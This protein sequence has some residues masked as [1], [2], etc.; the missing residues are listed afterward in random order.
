[1]KRKKMLNKSIAVLLS[2][3]MLL[4][5]PG[6]SFADEAAVTAGA[7]PQT[8]EK[9]SSQ[10]GDDETAGVSQIKESAQTADSTA[11]VE[12]E[13]SE[14][15][16]SS[17]EAAAPAAL[18]NKA[19]SQSE[20]TDEAEYPYQTFYGSAGGTDVNVTAPAGALPAGTK[21]RVRAVSSSKV[22]D[23]VE[24]AADGSDISGIQAL[25]ISFWKDG[26]EIE[27]KCDVTVKFSG[28][29]MKGDSID[30]YHMTDVNADAEKIDH[31]D[32]ATTA[33]VVS[34][35]FSIYVLVSLG[36]LPPVQNFIDPI[37]LHYNQST[38]LYSNSSLIPFFNGG[39][40]WI[41]K[42]DGTVSLSDASGGGYLRTPSVKVHA[43]KPGE[44]I[45]CFTYKVLE[46]H[47]ETFRINVAK[48]QTYVSYLDG[49]G[50]SATVYTYVGALCTIRGYSDAYLPAHSGYEFAGWSSTGATGPVDN[51]YAP[52]TKF[53]ITGSI[54]L[55]AV[56]RQISHNVSYSVTGAAP[57][58]YNGTV[59][60]AAVKNK[61]DKVTV[62]DALSSDVNSNGSVR[63]TW[64]FSGWTSDDAQIADDGTFVMPDKDVTLTGSWTFTA[65]TPRKLQYAF[66][67]DD[68]SMTLPAEV[69]DQL[70]AEND[71]CYA[72]DIMTAPSW[73]T[74]VPAVENGLTVGTWSFDRWL[75]PDRDVAAD[76]TFTMPDSDIMLTGIWVYI[77]ADKYG[78][79]YDFVSA[80][81]SKSLP[82]EVMAQLPSDAN[83]YYE[84]E[85][86]TAA[87]NFTSVPAV[88]NGITVGTWSFGAM[89]SEDV[90]IAEDGTFVMPGNDVRLTG[91]WNYTEAD[92]YKA[93]YK[94]VS[95]DPSKTLPS[96]VTDQLPSDSLD[97]YAGESVTAPTG[98]YDAEVEAN[99]FVGGTWH[100]TGWD[101]AQQTFAN[102]DV[103]FTGTW[104]Y[105][106]E[107]VSFAA[108]YKEYGTGNQ[109]APDSYGSGD[110]AAR[111]IITRSAAA[112]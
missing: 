107:T 1:M 48:D 21:M 36:G 111:S 45:I 84:G 78:V 102:G 80:D 95:A 62:A 79:S 14:K 11:S 110:P 57:S 24:S 33:K 56:W 65:A 27:P 43:N 76:N 13:V 20:K 99:G 31:S 96:D 104:E 7:V 71:E 50:N 34:D 63:G 69:L 52:G 38:T 92:K 105:E 83:T 35:E 85:E 108:H 3:A 16:S 51:S 58:S 41:Y 12:T 18:G 73:F 77:P 88:E 29:D 15:E 5:F 59:P 47:T 89:S 93:D 106:K 26:S 86:L 97:Y 9:E 28:I 10:S 81:T 42:D 30:V 101:K 64:S 60:A 91:T 94:F 39:R 46:E 70:P 74:S 19:E 32:S 44:A 72:G 75:A 67:P 2:L 112:D 90:Q 87:D 55:N 100:F 37:T 53:T 82:A 68:Y 23:A 17:S 103:T 98:F 6:V 54:I 61:G 49:Y 109:I 66:K 4:V 8:V 22:K 40:W 25:D